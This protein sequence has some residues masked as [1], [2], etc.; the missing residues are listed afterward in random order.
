MLF[1]GAGGKIMALRFA[2]FYIVLT[3]DSNNNIVPGYIKM[4]LRRRKTRDRQRRGP[5][6]WFLTQVLVVVVVVA[7]S[8]HKQV[9]CQS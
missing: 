8:I 6:L 5:D 1:L 2:I 7:G 3:I 4:R 9:C